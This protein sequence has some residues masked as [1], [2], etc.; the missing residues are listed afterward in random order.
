[1]GYILCPGV[2]VISEMID[3]LYVFFGDFLDWQFLSGN[4]GK[5]IQSYWSQFLSIANVIL[6]IAFLVIIYSIATSTGLTNYDVKKMLPRLLLFAVVINVSFYIC[7]VIADLSNIAGKGAYSMF[8]GM[9]KIGED[10]AA[11]SLFM[12]AITE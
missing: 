3:H 8:A 11:Q 1:M 4:S 5:Q 10:S 12:K 7:A 6:V 9:K 2:S